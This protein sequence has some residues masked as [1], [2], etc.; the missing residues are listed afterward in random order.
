[1]IF[2][3]SVFWRG[4]KGLLGMFTQVSFMAFH[5]LRT[6]LRR[7]T[8]VLDENT[9]INGTFRTLNWCEQATCLAPRLHLLTSVDINFSVFIFPQ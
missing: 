3:I 8:T 9:N 6:H 5:R 4:V 1:M 7:S 2:I